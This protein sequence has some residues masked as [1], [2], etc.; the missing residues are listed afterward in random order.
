[1]T[2]GLPPWLIVV[3]VLPPEVVEL[4]E[5]VP[6]PDVKEPVV[7]V[8]VGENE[9]VVG[10]GGKAGKLGKGGKLNCSRL[11]RPAQAAKKEAGWSGKHPCQLGRLL[12]CKGERA[13]GA[14]E[15]TFGA[16]NAVQ[17]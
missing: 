4:E 6:G 7:R 15:S 2:G 3:C 17:Y 8:P 13:P 12:T 9:V 14:A 16:T 10:M 11:R 5:K 1:M